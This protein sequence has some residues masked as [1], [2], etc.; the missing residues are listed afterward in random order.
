MPKFEVCNSLRKEKSR[1]GANYKAGF[2]D[3]A[4]RC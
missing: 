1:I 3:T 4:E 2:S